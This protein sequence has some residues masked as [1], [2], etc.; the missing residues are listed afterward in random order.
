MYHWLTYS[1]IRRC[2]LTTP[3]GADDDMRTPNGCRLGEL[4]RAWPALIGRRWR[5]KGIPEDARLA[6]RELRFTRKRKTS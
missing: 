1:D 4:S 2:W 6:G 5:H 3:I